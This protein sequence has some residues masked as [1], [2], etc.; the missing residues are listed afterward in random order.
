LER[1]LKQGSSVH[2]KSVRRFH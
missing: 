2:S 1:S